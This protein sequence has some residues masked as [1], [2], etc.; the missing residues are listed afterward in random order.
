MKPTKNNKG[1]THYWH[2][3]YAD[4]N[5][6]EEFF[7]GESSAIDFDN[8][9]SLDNPGSSYLWFGRDFHLNRS[10]VLELIHL[11]SYWLVNKRLPVK[12]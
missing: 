3:K 6:E 2:Q 5:K 12:G 10:E 7:L 8:D 11:L 1:L 9:D 4:Q